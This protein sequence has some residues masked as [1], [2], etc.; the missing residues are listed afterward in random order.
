M[1]I[2]LCYDTECD[3]WVCGICLFNTIQIQHRKWFISIIQIMKKSVIII[4]NW[5]VI[6]CHGHE[7]T[8]SSDPSLFQYGLLLVMIIEI[9]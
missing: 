8:Y 9:L 3:G 7:Y 2:S 1:I 5:S 6:I 4:Q